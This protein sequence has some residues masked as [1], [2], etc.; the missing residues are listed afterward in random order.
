M[1]LKSSSLLTEFLS[2]VE[3]HHIKKA[4]VFIWASGI[5]HLFWNMTVIVAIKV[6]VWSHQPRVWRL[7]LLS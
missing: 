5:A 2:K 6:L 7:L 1:V 3:I 4:L